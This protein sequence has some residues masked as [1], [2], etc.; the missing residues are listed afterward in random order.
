MREHLREAV[1]NLMRDRIVV[2]HRDAVGFLNAEEAGVAQSSISAD[3][4]RE[5]PARAQVPIE[6]NFP[7]VFNDDFRIGCRCRQE[8]E[9]LTGMTIG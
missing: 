9:E 6:C 8:G 4:D 2:E 5:Y 7:I 3:A 1:Q